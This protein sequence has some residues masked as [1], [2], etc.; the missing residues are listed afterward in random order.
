[1]RTV[2][3]LMMAVFLTPMAARSAG[4]ACFV[5]GDYDGQPQVSYTCCQSLIAFNV[6][7]WTFEDLGG[8]AIRVT[9]GGG[10]IPVMNGTL[11]CTNQSFT[12][13]SSRPGGCTETYT[14][15]GQFTSPGHWTATF[16]ATFSGSQ[17]S[18]FGGSL[19]L[20]CQNQQWTVSGTSRAL[21]VP[22][23]TVVARLAVGPNPFGRSI[24]IQL[25]LD[26]SSPVRAEVLDLQGRIVETLCDRSMPA[27]SQRLEWNRAGA[28]SGLYFLRLRVGGRTIVAKL[29]AID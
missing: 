17:C 25:D 22:A 20:P 8:G 18:F 4:A 5:P 19:G 21:S 6:S 29:V 28:P 10:S 27:G 24:A 2:S 13:T 26:R 14:L 11:N 1:M 12:A 3:L 7:S 16:S 15:T 23:D 9:P